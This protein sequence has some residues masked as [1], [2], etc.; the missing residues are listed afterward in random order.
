MRAAARAAIDKQDLRHM[1]EADLSPLG[2]RLINRE[3]LILACRRCGETW[4]PQLDAAGK[5]SFDY[6]LCPAKCNE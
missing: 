4:T 5:L 1:S 3:D 6:F 2:V